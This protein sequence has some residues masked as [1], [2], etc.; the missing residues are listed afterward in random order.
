[1]NEQHTPAGRPTPAWYDDAKLGIFVH[2]GLYSVPGWA[3]T[4]GTLDEAPARLGW[5]VWFRNNPYAEWYANT[6][7]IPGSPTAEHH[8]ATYGDAPYEAFVP[9]FNEAIRAW[10]PAAW[11]E[12]FTAAGAGY[13]VLTTKHHDGFRLWPSQVPHPTRGDYH[14]ARDLVGELA[15]AVRA[16]GLRFATYYSGGLDWTFNPT[17]V[18]DRGDV[19]GTVIQDPAYVAYADAHWRELIERYEP[20]ILWNDIGY[21]RRSDLPA[22]VEAYYRRIPDGLVNDRFQDHTGA[23]E[24]IP[25]VPPDFVTPEYKT[26][27]EIV[28]G[29]WESC[30]GIGFSFGYNRAE[31]E[32]TFISA[33]DLI[34]LLI[35]IVSKNGNL[36]LNVGPRADGSIQEGQI[37]RLRALGARLAVNGEAITGT[38]P[39][40]VAEGTTDQG[41]PVRFTRKGDALY[42]ILLGQP[43]PGPLHVLGLR[44]APHTRV[45]LLGHP[46]DLPA[47]QA[48]GA[49]R[50]GLPPDLP[51]SP[52][53]TLRIEPRLGG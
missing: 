40:T 11:A 3:P 32:A 12:L 45:S 22:I 9:A 34:H 27:G 33:P 2:W 35:D 1:M 51:E 30:R 42:A 41:I 21:P 13:V 15:G 49:L 16:A 4:T 52:A 48:E 14:A 39:W 25:L 6:M 28:P 24:A 46:A 8:R 20:A 29:K 31:H 38:R 53:H 44:A 5:D 47:A 36:L 17:V 50:V 23:G 37:S 43:Q 19:H 7:R 26:F 10:D 18:A